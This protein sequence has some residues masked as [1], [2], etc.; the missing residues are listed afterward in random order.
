MAA[1]IL[2]V[3]VKGER[4][5][6]EEVIGQK[7]AW[8]RRDRQ[9]SQA[10][11][12]EALGQYLDKPWSRQAVNSAERGNRAFTARDLIALALALGASVPSLLYPGPTTVKGG[13]ELSG[14]SVLGR[15]EYQKVLF[16]SGDA[17]GKAGLL[18]GEQLMLAVQSYQHLMNAHRNAGEA[19]EG[20]FHALELL[21]DT[22]KQEEEEPPDAMDFVRGRAE[23]K[24]GE[25]SDG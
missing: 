3:A 1:I 18:T 21:I 2:D 17:A 5:K 19:L 13:V 6:L 22:A 11:L 12:G 15:E 14:G 7:L 4:V 10:Q 16:A 23:R 24:Q 25:V 20:G 8:L 9:M